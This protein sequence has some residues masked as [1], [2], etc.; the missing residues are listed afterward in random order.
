MTANITQSTPENKSLQLA[1]HLTDKTNVA[2]MLSRRYEQLLRTEKFCDCVFH[3]GAE[4]VKCHKLILS[5]ASPVFEAMFY[6]PICEQ[7]E[8]EILDLNT[9]IFKLLVEYIYMGS[10]DFQHLTLEETIELYYGAEKYLLKELIGDC[11]FAITRKLRF[12]NILPA[13]ELSACMDL[14][15]LLEVCMSFFLRCCLTD[16][17]FMT[18]LKS[19]Y[20]HISKFCMKSIIAAAKK[21]QHKQLLWFA[22][23]WCQ[24]ECNELGLQNK[25]CGLIIDDLQLKENGLINS[26]SDFDMKSN[27]QQCC[28]VERCYYKACRP[29][30]VEFD[31]HEWTV[32]I[33]CDRFISLRGLIIHSRLTP[34]FSAIFA[35]TTHMPHAILSLPTEYNENV[36]IE[37]SAICQR[38]EIDIREPSIEADRIAE[39]QSII[40]HHTVTKQPIKYNCDLNISWSDGVV[41]SP[42]VEYQIK[43][44]WN[45]DAYGAEYPCSLQ[46][47]IVDGIEFKDFNGRNGSILKGLRFQNLI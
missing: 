15:G 41:L 33:K 1:N 2:T 12:S 28:S 21:E 5:A 47:D 31:N 30:I 36:R 39:N 20:V 6:G 34:N 46:S 27:L 19:N 32:T 40:W 25:D 7:R 16:P 24:Q 35:T 23:E 10:I 3:V 43:L 4:V 17:Q 22:Y 26:N 9:D 44:I 18:H 45:S 37:I 29:F 11:L 42:D 8:I 38:P 14:S 13:L